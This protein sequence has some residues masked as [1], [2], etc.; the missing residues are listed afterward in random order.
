MPIRKSGNQYEIESS[1][2]K[3]E[4]YKV[5]PDKPFCTCAGYRFRY[6]KSGG[7]CKHIVAVQEYAGKEGAKEGKSDADILAYVKKQETVDA[8]DLIGKFGDA[9]VDSLLKRGELIEQK[10]KIMLLR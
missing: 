8:L 10:G 2:R 4:F 1:S 7:V 5:D 9:A 3:G 6:L